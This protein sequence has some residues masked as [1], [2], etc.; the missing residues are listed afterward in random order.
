MKSSSR[1]YKKTRYPKKIIK[2]LCYLES[3]SR[4]LDD[5]LESYR[6]LQ[7]EGGPLSSEN[8][9]KIFKIHQLEEQMTEHSN[10][11]TW[12]QRMLERFQYEKNCIEKGI[13]PSF[14]FR[15]RSFGYQ[16]RL[17]KAIM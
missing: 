9:E 7:P 12:H 14:T 11:I 10:E 6:Y 15:K 5:L 4:H 2:L 3:C 17:P 8:I 1:I 16:A 13:E